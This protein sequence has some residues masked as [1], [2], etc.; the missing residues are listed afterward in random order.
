MPTPTPHETW[1]NRLNQVRERL[2]FTS[3]RQLATFLGCSHQYLS[4]V[5][6][7]L[8]ISPLT[9]L[10]LLDALGLELTREALIEVLP[11]EVADHLATIEERRK[12]EG[13]N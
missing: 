7:G 10:K 5:R 2:G 13:R 1:I 3:E 6:K 4:N 9:R 11:E 12:H 8:P